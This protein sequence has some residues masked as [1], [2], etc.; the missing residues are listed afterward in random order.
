MHGYPPLFTS[1]VCSWPYLKWEVVLGNVFKR[2]YYV[3]TDFK[4]LLFQLAPPA[5][6]R[7]CLLDSVTC[8]KG[9][10]SEVR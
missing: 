6:Q 1:V 3:Y 5:V 2:F 8:L 4:V 10:L 7:R 9:K